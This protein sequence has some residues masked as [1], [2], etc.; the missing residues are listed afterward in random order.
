MKTLLFDRIKS[1]E[2]KKKMDEWVD[3]KS[4]EDEKRNE[5]KYEYY[6]SKWKSYK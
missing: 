4:K 5:K 6:E 2:V 3:E 1:D